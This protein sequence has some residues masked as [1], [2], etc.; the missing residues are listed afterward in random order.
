MD[1]CYISR[2]LGSGVLRRKLEIAIQKLAKDETG[3]YLWRSDASEQMLSCRA[4][5]LKRNM[6]LT[7]GDQGGSQALQHCAY[8][9]KFLHV[10]MQADVASVLRICSARG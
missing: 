3:G 10:L 7:T 5:L 8:F 4:R 2:I 9:A 6:W 1:P